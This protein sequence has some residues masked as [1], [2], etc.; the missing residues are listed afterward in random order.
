MQMAAGITLGIAST[1]L[2]ATAAFADSRTE[3]AN[4][5]KRLD[6][7][8][9]VVAQHSDAVSPIY[10]ADAHELA[11]RVSDFRSLVET[12]TVSDANVSAQFRL[13]ARSYDRFRDQVKH[14]NTE[15]AR[16]DLETLAAPYSEV[17]HD[18]GI[19]PEADTGAHR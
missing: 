12:S 18:L 7:S 5:A 11:R 16:S 6:E 1:L 15:E 3:L 2:L 13:V 8:A 14:S 9:R 10:Q 17:E 19:T 4:A